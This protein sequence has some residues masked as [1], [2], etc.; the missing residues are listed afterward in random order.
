MTN[1]IAIGYRDRT[2]AAQ[3]AEEVSRRSADLSIEPDAVAVVVCGRDGSYQV[4]TNHQPRGSGEGVGLGA[5]MRVLDEAGVEPAFG[6][7]VRMMLAPG[8]SALFLALEA[9]PAEAAVEA[10]SQYRGEVMMTSLP[11]SSL[12][13]SGSRSSSTERSGGPS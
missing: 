13:W 4:T 7:G 8:T 5:V 10:L 6:A 9:T 11:A 3:A 2:T 12:Q 1:L